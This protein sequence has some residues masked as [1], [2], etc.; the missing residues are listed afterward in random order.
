M[1]ICVVLHP[2]VLYFPSVQLVVYEYWPKG[3]ILVAGVSDVTEAGSKLL[4]LCELCSKH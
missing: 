2:V 4:Y 3:A 1:G